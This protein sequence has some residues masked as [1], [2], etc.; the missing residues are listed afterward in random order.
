M[1]QPVIVLGATGQLGLHAIAGLLEAGR[2]I[3]AVVRKR[4]RGRH[5]RIPGLQRIDMAQAA[6][7]LIEGG[8]WELLSCGPIGLALELLEGCV[9]VRP[10]PW[11]RAVVIGTTSTVAK[12]RSRDEQERRSIE[13]IERARQ[14]VI[15]RCERAGIPLAVLDPTLIYGCG[16]D[17]NVS[18]LYAWI[19]RVGIVPVA[20]RAGG[21]RQPL[22]VEDLART[23]VTAMTT[24]PPPRMQSPVCGGSTLSFLDMVHRLFEA[25]GRRPRV[26]GLPDALY[27]ALAG[28]SRA[29]PGTIAINSEMLRR[30]AMDLVFDDKAARELLNHRGRSFRPGHS[31]F[32]L[33]GPAAEVRRAL[34]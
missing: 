24:E 15:D 23:C 17:H 19:R 22:H 7:L 27:P 29:L 5:T 4:P 33:A 1:T 32:G 8:G 3:V 14:G 13:A 25:T 31:D 12:R 18:R 16:M 10:Q 2:D 26:I 28:L 20:R 9:A 34:M 30:Q 6:E 11:S 21:L